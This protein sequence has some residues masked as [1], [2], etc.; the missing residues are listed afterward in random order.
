[1]ADVPVAPGFNFDLSGISF[2]QLYKGAFGW[3]SGDT[4]QQTANNLTMGQAQLDASKAVQDEKIQSDHDIQQQKIQA[5]TI[6]G[7]AI[8]GVTGLVLIIRS[9]W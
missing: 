7:L 8:A 4:K 2:D 3:I 6:T 9:I 5:F 1:M